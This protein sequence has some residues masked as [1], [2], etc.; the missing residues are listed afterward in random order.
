[1][2]VCNNRIQTNLVYLLIT[3]PKP[4]TEKEYKYLSR[5]WIAIKHLEL[6]LRIFLSVML[7]CLSKYRLILHVNPR[8]R[9]FGEIFILTI[10][11]RVY[12]FLVS[13]QPYYH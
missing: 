9:V 3:S 7:C 13:T 2:N 5:N 1:M 11:N 10:C 12:N 6:C 8:E 4:E